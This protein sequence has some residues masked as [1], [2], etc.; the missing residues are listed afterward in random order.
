V[1]PVI[2]LLLLVIVAIVFVLYKF[3]GTIGAALGIVLGAFALYAVGL[4]HL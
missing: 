2:A 3:Y 1:S 4:L